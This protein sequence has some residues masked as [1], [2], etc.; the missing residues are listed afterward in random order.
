MLICYKVME[1]SRMLRIFKN[2]KFDYFL[3]TINQLRA[4][5]HAKDMND[6]DESMLRGAF[7][8]FEDKLA[9]V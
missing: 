5:A 3:D 6:E 9:D 1:C 8:F 4:D 7:K 2:G